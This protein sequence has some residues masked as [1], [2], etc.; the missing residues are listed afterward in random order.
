MVNVLAMLVRIGGV[1]RQPKL[2]LERLQR[3]VDV[4]GGYRRVDFVKFGKAI[5]ERL[6]KLLD[7]IMLKHC[8]NLHGMEGDPLPGP[9]RWT[10]F[11]FATRIFPEIYQRELTSI[12]DV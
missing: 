4:C 11:S 12:I 5:R 6:H 7:A 10:V 8:A 9:L 1:A 3:R 2:T